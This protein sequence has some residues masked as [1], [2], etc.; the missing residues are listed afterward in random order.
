MG[1]PS[2]A[3]TA[4]QPPQGGRLAAWPPRSSF[5]T[6]AIGEGRS[7]SIS[8]LAGEM[9][10]RAEGGVKDLGARPLAPQALAV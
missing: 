7:A 2:A 4:P 10:G 3:R 8:P 9:P 6:S 1:F 5:S